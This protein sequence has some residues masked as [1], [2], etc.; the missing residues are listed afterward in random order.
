[1]RIPALLSC[2]VQI[3]NEAAMLN[4]LLQS[5]DCEERRV[6]RCRKVLPNIP[7]LALDTSA[8]TKL[9]GKNRGSPLT[10]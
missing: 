2:M 8:V 3:D 5:N 4:C 6:T 10:C 7:L 1:M 9:W